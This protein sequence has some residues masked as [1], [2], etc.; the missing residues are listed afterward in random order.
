MSNSSKRP[1]DRKSLADQLDQLQDQNTKE[2]ILIDYLKHMKDNEDLNERTAIMQIG[3][4]VLYP[5][6]VKQDRKAAQEELYLL[7]RKHHLE[8]AH[9]D[10]VLSESRK[11][12]DRPLERLPCA[13]V[14]PSEDWRCT[15]DGTMACANCRLVSYCSKVLRPYSYI[16]SLRK[17]STLTMKHLSL[18]LPANSLDYPQERSA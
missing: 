3:G 12:S 11:S 10:W 1:V 2:A 16:L 4:D 8:K 7:I 6:G 5:D 17:L 15:K 18:G 14:K 13:N 9:Y